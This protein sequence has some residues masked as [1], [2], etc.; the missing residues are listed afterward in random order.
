MIN[1]KYLCCTDTQCDASCRFYRFLK[2]L[3]SAMTKK[4][5]QSSA[6]NCYSRCTEHF[7]RWLRFPSNT[8]KE[9]NESTIQS[10]IDH[11]PICTCWPRASK[12]YNSVRA[13]L[14]WL[15]RSL[16]EAGE[17]PDKIIP[18][19]FIDI[20]VEKFKTY[21]VQVCGLSENTLILRARYLRRFLNAIYGNG[22]VD[23]EKL[24][25]YIVLDYVSEQARRCSRSTAKVIIIS[26]RSYFKFLSVTGRCNLD[27]YAAV[28]NIP[29]WKL[30]SLS[31]TLS[32]TEVKRV[33]S[34]F[35][36]STPV[37]KRNYAIALCFSE[38]G[39]RTCEVAELNIES[40]N[41][42]DGSIII[43]GLKSRRERIMPLLSRV[44]EAIAIY[45]QDVRVDSDSRKIFLRL[46]GAIGY[47]VSRGMVHAI[48]ARAFERCSISLPKNFGPHVFR[49]TL[50][51][52][53]LQQGNGIKNIA[54]MLG[55]KSIETA[56]IYTKI[57]LS[58]L[59]QV[60]LEW[61]EENK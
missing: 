21:L 15:L 46:R 3:S 40:I 43:P 35:N 9:I 41:W 7:F 42:S 28:P 11:L 50:A 57:D 58:M 56:M 13:A 6:I 26:L 47:P 55:H 33:L 29:Q 5:Y 60:A 25:P 2:C 54:D 45:L 37:G 18:M 1:T 14:N 30:S 34:S 36:R 32:D 24:T 38:L 49:H 20:E 4:N 59:T 44:G 52:K 27:L 61:P 53:M 31:M 48:I 16:R 23:I 8:G 51:G 19:T 22:I 39:L 10:F 12:S 17:I